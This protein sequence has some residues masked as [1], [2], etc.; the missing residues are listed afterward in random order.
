MIVVGRD[1]S[2][3]DAQ[4]RIRIPAKLTAKLSACSNLVLLSLFSFAIYF[5]SISSVEAG[6]SPEFYQLLAEV[7]AQLKTFQPVRGPVCTADLV[8]KAQNALQGELFTSALNAVVVKPLETGAKVGLSVL[9][10]PAA[11]ITTYSL[12]RCAMDESSAAGFKR[13]A[14]GEAI[15]F[16]AG[17]GLDK[18]GIDALTGALS[19]VAID[20]AYG[21]V[22]GAYESYIAAPETVEGEST[23]G[24][25][26]VKYRFHWDKKPRAGARG[27][28]IRFQA[29]VSECECRSPNDV[30]DGYVAGWFHVAYSPA[31][32]NQPGWKVK[33]FDQLHVE[34]QCCGQ[35]KRAKEKVFL[36]NPQGNIMRDSLTSPGDPVP[37]TA[38]P[39]TGTPTRPTPPPRAP[40]P[41]P[42][43]VILPPPDTVEYTPANPCPPCVPIQ[44][45]IADTADE[46]GKNRRQRSAKLGE[47]NAKIDE[48]RKVERQIR[49]LESRLAGERGTGASS[50]DPRTGI[51]TSARDT[52]DGR[53]RI[54]EVDAD[55]NQISERFRDRE[56]SAEITAKLTAKKQL[57]DGLEQDIQKI[58]ADI[59]ALDKVRAEL[60][61]KFDNLRADLIE[62][63]KLLCNK[64]ATCEQLL[65]HIQA[66]ESAGLQ[67]KSKSVLDNLKRRAREM[68]CY[69]VK[70]TMADFVNDSFDL[71]GT[72]PYNPPPKPNSGT[73]PNSGSA[74]GASPAPSPSPGSTT[75]TPA[76]SGTG[77]QNTND[78][79]SGDTPFDV[80]TDPDT[81][82]PK[83]ETLTCPQDAVSNPVRP[84]T[85]TCPACASDVDAY[86]QSVRVIRELDEKI[87]TSIKDFNKICEDDDDP[88]DV[89]PP[90]GCNDGKKISL[91]MAYTG[92]GNTAASGRERIRFAVGQ[93]ADTESYSDFDDMLS[94]I[95]SKLRKPID[96][97][98]VCR[99][100]VQKL[101]LM[102]HGGL[103]N[104]LAGTYQFG[105]MIISPGDVDKKTGKLKTSPRKLRMPMLRKLEKL[106]GLICEDGEIIFLQCNIGRQ[107]AGSISGQGV[108]NFFGTN[109][110]S[111][112]ISAEA[113]TCPT[114]ADVAS[115]DWK[116][117]DPQG[118]PQNLDEDHETSQ[119]EQRQE[120]LQLLSQS[121]TDKKEQQKR[122][123]ALLQRQKQYVIDCERKKC[124][125]VKIRDAISI[126]GNNPYD[127]RDPIAEDARE[128]G[129]ILTSDEPL[130]QMP[131][132][133]SP[134]TPT[135]PT[136][137]EP[138]V[139][140]VGPYNIP[141]TRLILVGPDA[142]PSDHYHGDA[143]DCSGT[144]RVDPAPGVCGHGTTA[145]PIPVSQCPDL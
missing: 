112:T 89:A 86:N 33:T 87:N 136:A 106:R 25:C 141:A 51:T 28:K 116:E 120:I 56:S 7:N 81:T 23:S 96:K 31:G 88:R 97:K 133:I 76:T 65:K 118:E 113:G 100:C 47:K 57:R 49:N 29:W 24:G 67:I 39:A 68:G 132:V 35:S 117:F 19:G 64:Y 108:S 50:T 103:G 102:Q 45:K 52:G 104:K 53:V 105:E 138:T 46:I 15:G 10:A 41:P 129:N 137:P 38:P 135:T 111:P 26:T 90:E 122:N 145:T 83:T 42:K 63:V 144:F 142:C 93:S 123:L 13:C 74:S 27:G 126:R 73:S 20:D 128:I 6:T 115:G 119:E 80:L 58:D 48:K 78:G 70:D 32:S 21:K 69:D 95:A 16:G 60:S 107:K 94:I 14:L 18:A 9:G 77:E 85:S 71:T 131:S 82:S 5:S 124:S 110:R 3:I 36:F 99:D 79:N 72:T 66:Y 101:I 59:V 134:T 55:G 22:R 8:D 12:M 109:V 92:E 98:G 62:C 139:L 11:A 127:P 140:V 125:K 130:I 114:D 54:T 44:Q 4:H 121:I 1:Q 84:I 34:A 2:S 61:Q 43:P 40:P 30:E 143:L 91:G 37:P 75:E 17:K